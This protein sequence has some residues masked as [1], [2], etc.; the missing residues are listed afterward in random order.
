[1]I[2]VDGKIFAE[3][4]F[5]A[6]SDNKS[7]EIKTDFGYNIVELEKGRARVSYSDCKDGL[8]VGAGWI[9]KPNQTVICLPARL[10]VKL[11]GRSRVD[12]VSY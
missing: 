7:V 9:D 3:Y 8:C 12:R 6:I 10:E 11:K 2:E 5:N 1:M 4:D